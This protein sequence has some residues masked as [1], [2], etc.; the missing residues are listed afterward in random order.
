MGQLIPQ[1]LHNQAMN[2][3]EK[4]PLNMPRRMH[5]KKIV[6]S[7]SVGHEGTRYFSAS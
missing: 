3:L 5:V 1:I 7:S 4:A 2:M 6:F